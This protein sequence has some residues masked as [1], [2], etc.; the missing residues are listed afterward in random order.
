MTNVKPRIEHPT[1]MIY[2]EK[3][4]IPKSQNLRDFA[5]NLDVVSLNCGHHIQQETF[6]ET[7]EAILTWLANQRNNKVL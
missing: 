1:L 2:G 5:P 3:D 4:V 6:E 7:N